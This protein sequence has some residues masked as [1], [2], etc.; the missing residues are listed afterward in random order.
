LI[1]VE[2][3]PTVDRVVDTDQAVG[4]HLMLHQLLAGD[5]GAIGQ[6]EHRLIPLLAQHRRVVG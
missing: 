5:R 1:P 2:V 3:D 4:G 6:G